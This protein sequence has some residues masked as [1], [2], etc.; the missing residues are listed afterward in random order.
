MH[1]CIAQCR[2][3]QGEHYRDHFDGAHWQFTLLRAGEPGPETATGATRNGQDHAAPPATT[4]PPPQPAPATGAVLVS[5]ADVQPER[6]SWLWPGRVPL[7]KLTVL[8]GDPGL[9]KSAITTDLAARVSV[10]GT[11][12]D[13]A[14]SDLD[15]PAGVVLLSAE[16]DLADT[17][18]PRLDAAGADVSRI[19]ALKAVLRLEPSPDPERPATARPDLPTV[20][21]LDA[22]RE[23]IARVDARLVVVDP[24]MAFLPSATNSFRDADVRRVLAP[25]AA[26]AAETDVAVVAVR[27][28]NKATGGNPLYRGGGSIGIIGAV[29]SGL[30]VA[31]DP[32]LPDGARRIL[33]SSKSNLSEPP[34]ALAYHLEAVAGGAV[35]VV[36]EGAVQH[37]ASSLL[38]QSAD[39]EERG[40]LAEARD[41]LRE[42]LADGPS[43]AKDV[44]REARAAGISEIT[45]RRAK[46][47]LGITPTKQGMAGPWT[48]QLP[49]K[50]LIHPED[51]HVQNNEHLQ[52]PMSTFGGELPWAP[53]PTEREEA[54]L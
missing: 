37:T 19:V 2:P 9:G 29:R 27:H 43:P 20:A 1:D 16:D 52:P 35:R 45:L 36:W 54:Q 28:L 50:M 3:E 33:A 32:D 48:W 7:G 39:G 23:A 51:A 44:Q 53:T 12:P 46:T 10:G 49:P 14:R 21:D 11:M 47:A 8:D 31:P 15:G 6:V 42:L 25:L 4:M 26:L 13:G 38:A 5:L 40:A 41:F 18:R 22:I 24:V 34:P 17:I 30:L